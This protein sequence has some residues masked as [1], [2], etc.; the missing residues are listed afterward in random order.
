[1]AENAPRTGR[2]VLQKLERHHER[3]HQKVTDG[4]VDNVVIGD[5]SHV[6]VPPHRPDDHAVP[7]DRG[8]DDYGVESDESYPYRRDLRVVIV[9][10][11]FGIAAAS[12]IVGVVER[13]VAQ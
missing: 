13:N 6:L 10:P 9:C 7:Y 2:R 12:S 4:Q 1:M 8:N 3:R 11:V 5:R